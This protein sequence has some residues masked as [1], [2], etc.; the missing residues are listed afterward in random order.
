MKMLRRLYRH[1][2]PYRWWAV[3]ALASMVTVAITNGALVGLMRPL[4]DEV[5]TRE[6][7]RVQTEDDSTRAIDALL[8]RDEPE[9]QRGT[10]VN[11]I[12]RA[13]L[14]ARNWWS[15]HERDRWKLIPVILLIVFLVRS[16]AMFFSHYAFERV[17]LSTIRDFRN[18]LYESIIHQS[19]RFF[20][21][22][23]T[24]EL[25]SRVVSDVDSIQAAVSI[26]MGDLFQESANLIVLMVFVLL[27]HTELAIVS[28][29]VAP[30]IVWPIVQFGK[31]LR[32]FSRHSQE[33]MADVATVLEETIR[34][35]RIV[36]AFA[37]EP[38]E[39]RRFR[40]AT[41]RHFAVNLKA[42]RVQALSSPVLELLGGTC[43]VL[44]IAYAGM[45]IH[46]GAMTIGQFVSFL[47]ALA[48]MY[49][50]IKRLNQ[51]NLAMNTA[52]SA[53]ER[54]F[55]MLDTENEVR[56]RSDAIRLRTI[57]SGVS[58][59]DV[60][61]AYGDHDILSGV[62]LDV[63]PGEM[64]AIVGGSG[65]GKSTLVNLLPRFYDVSGGA[66]LVDGHDIR[67]VTLDS[68]RGLIG[69]V[70]QEVVLFNDTIRNNIAYGRADIPL[71][72]V[73]DAARAANASGFIET[74]PEGYDTLVGEAGVRLSGGQRQRLAIARALLKN[75]PILILDEATSAL[76]TESERLV[77]QAL[78]HLMEGRTTLVI[79]HRLSTV[80]RANRIIVLDGGVITEVGTHATLIERDG[81]YRRLYEMQFADAGHSSEALA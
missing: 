36:K 69:F 29:V 38:F 24:G 74:L 79:A 4:F 13:T 56:D 19:A 52:L 54:V 63:Q 60:S 3:L 15:A 17:G 35:V 65:A 45:R 37:M 66:I 16:V 33:R 20:A 59:R 77:Q 27:S 44:L 5:L 73:R 1:V 21:R 40:E 71:E 42:R 58:Y 55:Q 9:G 18:Q 22:K 25:V 30:L 26:R 57:G 67:D 62:S 14:E 46:A 7:E 23:S 49:T 68:L 28:F 12:D 8:R 72:R 53:A 76:D 80:R 39:V 47:L 32:R 11:A 61:F 41:Q 6:G 50:P 78:N 31:R 34:G 48:M 2:L 70:T 81:T 51:V 64:V 10:I 75:P 43:M